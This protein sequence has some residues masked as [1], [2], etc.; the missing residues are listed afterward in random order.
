MCTFLYTH[1]LVVTFMYMCITSLAVQDEFHVSAMWP[2]SPCIPAVS[3]LCLL[4]MRLTSSPSF[5]DYLH[6]FLFSTKVHNVAL[7]EN[8]SEDAGMV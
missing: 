4:F 3:C 6:H 7:H 2:G 1:N 8:N 5:T